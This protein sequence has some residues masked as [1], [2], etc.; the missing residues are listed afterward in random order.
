MKNLICF[1]FGLALTTTS[2]GQGKATSSTVHQCTDEMKLKALIRKGAMTKDFCLKVKG[3]DIS[4]YVTGDFYKLGSD[5][6]FLV[7]KGEIPTDI[8]V[9]NPY[10]KPEKPTPVLNV[11]KSKA[12]ADVFAKIANRLVDKVKDLKKSNTAP[13]IKLE[14]TGYAD[15]VRNL[16]SSYDLNIYEEVFKGETAD[17]PTDS[18]GYMT[19]QR[20][21]FKTAASNPENSKSR[22]GP[23]A[24]ESFVKILDPVRNIYLAERR[25][26]QLLRMIFGGKF[27]E[28][29][30][31]NAKITGYHTQSLATGEQL[32]RGYCTY[33]RGAKLNMTVPSLNE[34][35]TGEPKVRA[36]PAPIVSLKEAHYKRFNYINLLNYLKEVEDYLN[37]SNHPFKKRMLG[38]EVK[39]TPG[40][41]IQL[42]TQMDQVKSN[43]VSNDEEN[44]VEDINPELDLGRYFQVNPAE[45]DIPE[46]YKIMKTSFGKRK[47]K[48]PGKEKVQLANQIQEEE[49]KFF[50]DF[51]AH[52]TGIKLP[53]NHIYV[54][55]ARV[56]FWVTLGQIKKNGTILSFLPSGRILK[57]SSLN[58]V[59]VSISPPSLGA[60]LVQAILER[61]EELVKPNSGCE[62]V[63][64]YV[65]DFHNPKLKTSVEVEKDNARRFLTI[66]SI[67]NS[68]VVKK[69]ENEMKKLSNGQLFASYFD[70]LSDKKTIEE[71]TPTPAVA[72][73]A[74]ALGKELGRVAIDLNWSDYF[75]VDNN[76]PFLIRTDS[77]EQNLEAS[78][79][80]TSS[81]GQTTSVYNFLNTRIGSLWALRHFPDLYTQRV[82]KP[83][84]KR[85][86]VSDIYL[87][88][89]RIT[90]FDKD[91]E[92]NEIKG[93]FHGACNSGVIFEIGKKATKFTY[94]SRI[95]PRDDYVRYS[96]ENAQYDT[97]YDLASDVL[98]KEPK[99]RSGAQTTMGYMNPFVMVKTKHPSTYVIPNCTNCDCMKSF[100]DRYPLDTDLSRPGAKLQPTTFD[101]VYQLGKDLEDFLS[102]KAYRMDFH[103]GFTYI[104][105]PTKDKNAHAELKITGSYKTEVPY[106]SFNAK[107]ILEAFGKKGESLDNSYCLYSPVIPQAHEVGD[108]ASEDESEQSTPEEEFVDDD[109]SLLEFLE[110]AKESDGKQSFPDILKDEKEVENIAGYC[111]S[112]SNGLGDVKKCTEPGQAC[113]GRSEEIKLKY[114]D[115]CNQTASEIGTKANPGNLEFCRDV[116]M[117]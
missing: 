80:K 72:A 2:W 40:F 26:Q 10:Q 85:Q 48:S 57:Y 66:T 7:P 83:I 102:T 33:R 77:Y 28:A 115:L 87:N 108:G 65:A 116:L 11:E 95:I 106:K 63:R 9:K 117:K 22:V 60:Y 113:I 24:P 15:G 62:G 49:K 55:W 18:G 8:S 16:D 51:I 20:E 64:G 35:N 88:V 39:N 45:K 37:Q 59:E 4:L 43:K 3:D 94:M 99:I 30:V 114:K 76:A 21:E 73:T 17:F 31:K 32:C 109:C 75:E 86:G 103:S 25:A 92:R 58:Q 46:R 96:D 42:V 81:Q 50:S 91:K 34:L 52:T 82:V 78:I 69:A 74:A 79:V 44:K 97:F 107:N 29:I 12:A 68:V 67:Y 27:D 104:K 5:S 100:I 36:I 61:C 41:A 71:L 98:E 111:M 110:S 70:P 1:M 93:F 90:S 19:F 56:F 23:K 105:N 84:L 38:L 53:L 89:D 112:I 54:Q 101:Q 47:W 6:S 14:A 13:G